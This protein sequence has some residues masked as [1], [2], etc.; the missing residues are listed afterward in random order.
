M[1]A[2][3]PSPIDAAMTPFEDVPQLTLTTK[4][5][6]ADAIKGVG[7]PTIAIGL[8][9]EKEHMAYFAGSGQ[10]GSWVWN[11]EKLATLPEEKLQAL[12]YNLKV[13]QHGS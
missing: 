12:Y 6:V 13:A 11:M 10:S 3:N 9:A 2:E 4:A 1:L 7:F 8:A 5:L